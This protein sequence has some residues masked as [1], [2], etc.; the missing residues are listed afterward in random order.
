MSEMLVADV[1]LDKPDD[2]GLKVTAIYSRVAGVYVVYSNCKRLMVHYADDADLAKEQRLALAHLAPLRGEIGGL[3]EY[4]REAKTSR[5]RR[6]TRS[7]DRRTADAL[8][9]ALQGDQE[10]A[11][12]LLI[13]IKADILEERASIGRAEYAGFA[14]LTAVVLFLAFASLWWKQIG[15]SP[16]AADAKSEAMLWFSACVGCLGALFSIALGIR[17]RDVH[18]DLTLLDNFVDACLRVIIGVISAVVLFSLIRGNLASVSLGGT[19]IRLAPSAGTADENT[20][21]YASIVV[22]FLAGFSER[23]VGDFLGKVMVSGAV[24]AATKT[25]EPASSASSKI[26]SDVRKADERNPLGLAQQDLQTSKH[27]EDRITSDDDTDE[28]LCGTQHESDPR[29]DDSELPIAAGGVE[30]QK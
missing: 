13:A 7:F 11:S 9:V 15:I 3:L 10:S 25:S 2:T 6:L 28:C 18:Y 16:G 24:T 1:I 22:A 12:K 23:L 17:G 14:T 26:V 4:W 30:A 19:P 27:P 20:I 29:T 5:D 21:K 8:I